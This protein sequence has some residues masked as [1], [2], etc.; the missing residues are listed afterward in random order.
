MTIKRQLTDYPGVY[1][2]M[3]KRLGKPGQA[4]KVY[5]ITFK[6]DGKKIEERVLNGRQ[7]TNK[8]TA[9]KANAY[10]SRRI[11]GKEL[12]PKQIRAAEVNKRKAEEGKWTINKLWEQYKEGRSFNRA[13]QTDEGRYRLYIK[14][15]LGD[16][17]PSELVPLDIDRIRI[18]LLKKKSPQTVKHVLAL[19]KRICNFG[20]DKGL[21]A[22]L[23]FRIE[24][25]SVDNV[26]TE[27][28]SPEQLASL[29]EKIEIADSP[30]AANMMLMAL[31]TGMR[32]GE[33]FRLQWGD[34]DFERG[35]ILLRDPKG[36]KSQKIPMNV[37]A[38]KVLQG[39]PNVSSYVFPGRY[40]GRLTNIY[41]S[42]NKIK[43]AA[44]L[45]DDFRVLH[46]LRHVYATMLASSGQVDMY[47][48]QK[49]MT[50]KSPQMTQRY[51]HLR[52]D[53]LK[54]ASDLAG[55]II[56]EAIRSKGYDSKKI[57]N[58]RDK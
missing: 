58:V 3:A 14:K 46:G 41:G 44:G 43:K 17:E 37:E 7:Y 11:Q 42:V 1:F 36:G 13:F 51:A 28:L 47:T 48:L 20:K 34:V 39:A 33:M 53:A 16:R 26:S 8:M 29:L 18:K 21:S 30:T 32:R 23:N 12:S 5:Y 57:V 35:F 9:F 56:S 15:T 2:R 55:G 31:Y 22:G 52:D 54:Q 45:P 4:E 38:R 10:R 19:I 25:P 49:L 27:D 6:K 40:G 50:H 24:M